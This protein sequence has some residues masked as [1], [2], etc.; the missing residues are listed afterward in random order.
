MRF[1]TLF[2]AATLF[3]FCLPAQ[4]GSLTAQRTIQK[5]PVPGTDSEVDKARCGDYLFYW[6]DPQG[7]KPKG[8]RLGYIA[9]PTSGDPA[10]TSYVFTFLKNKF[11]FITDASKRRPT[12]R[13]R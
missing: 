2:A 6:A 12:A 1:L 5:L 7:V 11:V 3:S 9:E 8:S 13:S 4:T 10:N